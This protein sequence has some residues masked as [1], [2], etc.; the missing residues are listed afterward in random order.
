MK[1]RI[2]KKILNFKSWYHHFQVSDPMSQKTDRQTFRKKNGSFSQFFTNLQVVAYPL[3]FGN[4]Q[5]KKLTYMVFMQGLLTQH[6]HVALFLLRRGPKT[7][8]TLTLLNN[9]CN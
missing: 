7:I 9:S 5:V 6:A 2:L 4:W 8:F 1:Y 3:P